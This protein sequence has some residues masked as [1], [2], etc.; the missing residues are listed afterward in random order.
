M[1]QRERQSGFSTMVILLVVLVVAVLAA[2]GLVVY[3]HHKPSSAKNS[4]ATSLSQ[5]TGQQQSTTS[6][7]PQPTTY[8]YIKEW[9]VKLPL[10]DS[11]KDAYYVVSNGSADANGQPNTMW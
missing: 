7:Q 10:S 9:G 1:R 2:T 4:A 6:T 8:L 11:I 5:P 3:Q